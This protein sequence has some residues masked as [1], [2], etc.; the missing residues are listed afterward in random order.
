MRTAKKS[1]EMSLVTS[2]RGAAAIVLALVLPMIIGIIG[3]VIDVGLAYSEKNALQSSAEAGALAATRHI[4]TVNRS[5]AAATA[6]NYAA[7]NRPGVPNLVEAAEVQLG[8]WESGVF[9]A[10]GAINAVRVTASRTSSKSNALK[11]FFAGLF[12]LKVWNLSSSAIATA[13]SPTCILILHPTHYDAFDVDPYARI[14]APECTVQVNSNDG[15][16]LELGSNS[17]VNVKSV[18]VV[19]GVDKSA[20]AFVSPTPITGVQAVADPY[21]TLAPPTNN[22]CGGASLIKNITTS[23]SPVFAFCNG[24]VID[25]ATVTFQPGIYVVKGSFT[26]RNGAAIDG[27]GV[28]IYMEGAGHDLFFYSHTSFDLKAP[29]TGPYAGIVLWSDKN[30]TNDHDI[31]S[32]FGASASGTIYAPKSQVEFENNVEWEADCIR[33]VV[34][35]LELDNNSKYK[36]ID[37]NTRCTQN[38]SGTGARLVR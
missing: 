27:T 6:A 16:A 20:S 29:T 31:Y 18:R 11:T 9:S 37:P 19:G 35:R 32:K 21:A 15:G 36:A 4:G 13:S 26:L 12:G 3:L 25:A 22:T 33:I 2:Q 34:A 38:I 28:L 23:I 30:N 8:H 24:L 14:D 5:G 7:L 17:Y 1:R 10:S